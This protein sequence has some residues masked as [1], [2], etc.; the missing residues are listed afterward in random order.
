MLGEA[1]RRS[2]CRVEL[3]AQL[4][5]RSFYERAGFRKNGLPLWSEGVLH[6]PMAK[7]IESG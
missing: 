2:F 6:Q 1:Q 7:T 3:L 4:Y 5:A